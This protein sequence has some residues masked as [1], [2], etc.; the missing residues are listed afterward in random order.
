VARVL[1]RARSAAHDARALAGARAAGGR[2]GRR[3]RAGTRTPHQGDRAGGGGCRRRLSP[4]ARR[5]ARARAARSPAR[6]RCRARGPAG[7]AVPPAAPAGWFYARNLRLYGTPLVGN[8]NLPGMRWWS[9]PGF[10]TASYYLGFGESLR[11]P[12]LAGFH[13]LADSLYSS[14]WGDGWI[15]GR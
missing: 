9:Q 2:L 8:W 12:V 1:V 6:A 14:F 4:L 15:A 10:H 3:R 7:R 11:L 5:A 13:S